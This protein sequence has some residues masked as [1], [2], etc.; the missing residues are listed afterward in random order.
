M[1]NSSSIKVLAT[2]SRGNGLLQEDGRGDG[3]GSVGCFGLA[4]AA[5]AASSPSSLYNT[6]ILSPLQFYAESIT[7]FSHDGT[8]DVKYNVVFI[9][10]DISS[11]RVIAA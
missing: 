8:F 5:A 1:I 11:S 4:A 3:R 6:I 10:G 9:N 2:S 7:K